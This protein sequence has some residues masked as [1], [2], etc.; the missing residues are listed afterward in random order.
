ML[1]R[2]NNRRWVGTLVGVAIAACHSQPV[3]GTHA[4][5]V[6]R[7]WDAQALATLEVPLAR[8]QYSPKNISAEAY[9]RIP[10]RP[11]Y[12]SY[13]KY[14]PDKE[15][16]AYWAWL[17]QQEPVVLWDEGAHRPK[18]VT[19]EDWIRAGDIVFNAPVVFTPELDHDVQADRASDEKTGDLYDGNGVSPFAT[20]VIRTR[21]T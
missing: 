21:G 3:D 16:P 19:E 11:I 1:D 18:L 5:V 9:Y 13:P 14:R 2:M 6:P 10:V 12:K 15:P 20:H 7:T 8:A 4:T 17:K